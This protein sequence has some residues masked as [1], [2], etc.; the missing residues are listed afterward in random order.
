MYEYASGVYAMKIEICTACSRA[1]VSESVDT[2]IFG[3]LA[4]SRRIGKNVHSNCA[5]QLRR[6]I[7]TRMPDGRVQSAQVCP[8][9]SCSV[10]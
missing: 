7:S 6:K 3:F 1:A 2:F 8:C 9:W 5:T 10:T 4:R